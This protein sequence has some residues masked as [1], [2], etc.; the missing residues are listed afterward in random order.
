MSYTHLTISERAKIETYL[1]LGYSI[2]RIALRLKR[3]PSTISREL[4]RHTNCSIEEAHARYQ[5]N[6]SN[7]GAKLKFTTEVNEVVQEKLNA[8]WSPE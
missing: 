7:C 3:S 6:K 8:T 5:T 1:D 4:R 2:R